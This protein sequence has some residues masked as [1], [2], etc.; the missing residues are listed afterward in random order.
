MA[1]RRVSP[2]IQLAESWEPYQTAF[3][4]DAKRGSARGRGLSTDDPGF[5]QITDGGPKYGKRPPFSPFLLFPFSLVIRSR[6]TH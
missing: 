6:R 4:R 3:V 2:A 1:T 5:R